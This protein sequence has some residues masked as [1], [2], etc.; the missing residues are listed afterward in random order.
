MPDNNCLTTIA[1]DLLIDCNNADVTGLE[2]R[3]VLINYSDI[4][5]AGIVYSGSDPT[6]KI[7]SDII[8]NA[9]TTG[10]LLEG[11]K[12]LNSFLNE[13][14]ISDDAVNKWR[15]S[16][17]GQVRNLTATARMEMD[18]MANGRFLVVVEKRWKGVDNESA[19]VVLGPQR[20]LRLTVGVENSAEA[21]GVYVFTIA[22]E[23]NALESLGAP[24][25]FDTDFAT[26][27]AEFENLFATP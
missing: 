10:Y 9:A 2:E 23:D 5:P 24:L 14:V 7:V 20:G 3:V 11:V 27:L 26:S 16:F 17:V 25:F 18:N 13:N 8:L 4:A 22:S 12:Q 6:T 15:H 19:F 1:N 21:E